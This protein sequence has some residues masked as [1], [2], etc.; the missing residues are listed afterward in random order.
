M[1][2]KNNNNDFFAGQRT[3]PTPA[4]KLPPKGLKS[5]FEKPKEN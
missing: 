3:P 1:K 5:P 4:S 2:K